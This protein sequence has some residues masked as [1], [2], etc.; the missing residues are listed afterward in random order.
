MVIRAH[1]EGKWL[2]GELPL[3]RVFVR[4]CVESRP[5]HTVPP[6]SRVR[7]A[8]RLGS[9]AER[10]AVLRGRSLMGRGLGVL[11]YVKQTRRLCAR[12]RALTALLALVHRSRGV[13]S[14]RKRASRHGGMA[15]RLTAPRHAVSACVMIHGAALPRARGFPWLLFFVL[16]ATT[17]RAGPRGPACCERGGSPLGL[18]SSMV[19]ALFDVSSMSCAAGR[20]A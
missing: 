2:R 15:G 6:C 14:A 10:P 1:R 5:A 16:H 8:A 3:Q 9:C 7:C 4:L 19:I 12:K 13:L 11:V 18:P 17:H 20:G